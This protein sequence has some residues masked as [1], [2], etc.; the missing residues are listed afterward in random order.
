MAWHNSSWNYRKAITVSNSGSAL[1][2]YQVL[3]TIDT[4]SLVTAGKLLSSCNDI[5]F[6]SSD[7]S[8]ILNYWIE[9]GCNTSSTKIWVKIPSIANGTNTIYLYY[10]NTGA[11]AASN[12]TNTFEMYDQFDNID[13]WTNVTAGAWT[14]SPDA[15]AQ[16]GNNVAVGTGAT[17]G[18]YV[19]ALRH[20]TYQ[21]GSTGRVRARIKTDPSISTNAFIVQRY[22]DGSNFHTGYLQTTNLLYNS[23]R[24]GS[25]WDEVYTSFTWSRGSWVILDI[26]ESAQDNYVVTAN[27]IVS[28][29][30]NTVTGITSDTVALMVAD[31]GSYINYVDWIFV[32]KYVTAEPT[33]CVGGEEVQTPSWLTGWGKRKAI[34]VSGSTAGVRTDYQIKLIAHKETGTDTATDIYLGTGTNIRDDFGDLRFTSQDG[35][36]NLN[37]WIESIT[38]SAPYIATVWIKIPSIPAGP[39][40]TKIYGYYSKSSETTTSNGTNTFEF[41]DDFADLSKWTASSGTWVISSP[42]VVQSTAPTGYPLIY[43]SFSTYNNITVFGKIQ[44]NDTTNSLYYILVKAATTGT[45]ALN[46]LGF[47]FGR[48]TVRIVDNN[49]V[50]ASV[51]AT[52]VNATWYNY[53]FSIASDNSII[54]RVWKVSDPR[55][56][57]PTVTCAAFTPASTGLNIRYDANVIPGHVD[58]WSNFIIRKYVSPEPTTCVGGEEVQTPSWLTDWNRRK[59][60][61]ITGSTSGTQTDYQME[62]IV[63]KAT[64]TDTSTDIYVGTNVNNDFSDLR[65]TSNDGST[66]LN[67]WIE[68]YTSGSVA[69]VWIKIPSVPA[70]PCTTTIY[71]YY[72][73]PLATSS[74]NGTNTFLAFEGLKTASYIDA[75]LIPALSP[76]VYETRIRQTSGAHGIRFGLAKTIGQSDADTSR[77]VSQNS[78]NTIYH[79]EI[80]NA[81][82]TRET[83]G[84]GFVTSQWYRGKIIRTPE[85]RAFGYIDGNVTGAGITTNLP[86]EAMGLALDINNGAAEQE[87]SFVRKYASSEPTFSTIGTEET[88]TCGTPSANLVVLEIVSNQLLRQ[89]PSYIDIDAISKLIDNYR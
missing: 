57:S 78:P 30:A 77:L 58:Y 85:P 32:A 71:L 66:N 51:G 37:Y 29:G 1:T 14:S 36:T 8:T 3:V 41:F 18:I 21:L 56:A 72:G 43:H 45:D 10:N 33:T 34:T 69:T 38:G 62:L 12:G 24:I 48:S 39:C 46:G 16:H 82:Y 7:G 60:I 49:V 81:I 68:S 55:P 42:N 73:N 22:K 74:S 54:A 67:Y 83:Y 2:D 31:S 6:T 26:K 63:H 4:S 19:R 64:G 5:R 44:M 53:E 28:T 13:N 61:T 59:L 79:D 47:N 9:S 17:G 86:N 35:S 27:D 11:S 84:T 23:G 88:Y 75:L 76:Y 15:T 80:N 87:W 50:K 70:N 20:K 25:L 89:Y 52:F 65:F 40:T